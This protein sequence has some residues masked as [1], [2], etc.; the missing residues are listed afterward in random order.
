MDKVQVYVRNLWYTCSVKRPH[1]ESLHGVQLVYNGDEALN[2]P[3]YSP[4]SPQVSQGFGLIGQSSQRMDSRGP[5]A[6]V[7]NVNGLKSAEGFRVGVKRVRIFLSEQANTPK[8]P[9]QLRLSQPQSAGELYY[10]NLKRDSSK[11]F[12]CMQGCYIQVCT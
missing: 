7:K 10:P 3:M 9:S 1:T 4:L 11:I 5:P 6:Y 12:Y 8:M 2:S